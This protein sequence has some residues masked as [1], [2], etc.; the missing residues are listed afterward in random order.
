M[1]YLTTA[2]ITWECLAGLK[3]ATEERSSGA[4]V[5]FVGVVRRDLEGARSVMALSY[6]AYPEM[7]ERVIDPLID[8]AKLRWELDSVQIQHRLGRVEVGEIS[9]V[10]V[11]AAQHRA[12][13]YAASQF[14]IEAIKRDAPIW[15]REHYDDGTSE[16]AIDHS[17]SDDVDA[18]R[19]VNAHL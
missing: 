1:K 4:L 10:I 9:V 8:E 12:A 16:W 13:A 15:K 5:V 6:E 14:L 19:S 2:S 18:A 3:H 7:C 17:E 11:V